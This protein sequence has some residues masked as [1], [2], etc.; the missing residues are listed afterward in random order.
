[1]GA[2][3][4][5]TSCCNGSI[6]RGTRL[7]KLSIT[8]VNLVVLCFFLVE[9]L[10]GYPALGDVTL[11]SI[12]G[13][14][15]VL[16]RGMKIPVWGTAD[17]NELVTV[18]ID[19]VTVQKTAGRDGRWML[20]LGKMEAGGPYEMTV[21]GYNSITFTNVMIGEVWVCSGQSNM[22]MTVASVQGIDEQVA[23]AD[24]PNI[25]HFKVDNVS[26][27]QPQFDFPGQKPSWVPCT[28]DT[29]GTFS[30]V[31]FFFGRELYQKLDVPIGL[32]HTSWGGSV[33]EAWTSRKTLESTP[34][35]RPIVENLDSLVAAYPEARIQYQK[36]HAEWQKAMADSVRPLPPMP[37]P[38]MGPGMNSYPSGLYNAMLAPMIP[39]GIAGVIWYQGE[40]NSVRAHQYRTLFPAMITDWRR[41]WNQGDFPFLF[42]QIANWETDTI[43]VEGTWGSW[44]ELREAQLM[45]L[46]L[47]NI[48]MA[49]TIDIGDAYNIHPNNKWDVGHRLALNALQKAY[50]RNIVAS[51]PVYTAMYREGNAVRLRF[52]HIADGLVSKNDE[53][54]TGFQIAGTDR[55]FHEAAARIA[56]T[57][58]VVSSEAVPSPAAVRYG[59]DDNPS[60]NLFNTE[61]LPASPFRT[62]DWPCITEGKLKP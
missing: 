8:P 34:E 42:V 38:P 21:S 47:P 54:L 11:P 58:V 7:K 17:S 22:A 40:S 48:G 3:R 50:G 9:I 49:V 2:D 16:Q 44:A 61:G 20:R 5:K 13:D 15:M 14:N 4:K 27:E 28:P 6:Q 57:E 19:T 43:P 24:F 29:V 39:Y 26:T 12:F 56:G 23:Q 52:R 46:S 55:V 18:T 53:P 51:G 41:A 1:M 25:R 30:A 10:S 33:A 35:L 37:L 60:C 62:D 59:W 36:Q 45:T 32:V 31:A